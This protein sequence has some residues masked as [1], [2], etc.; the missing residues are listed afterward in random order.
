MEA[1]KQHGALEFASKE[2]QRDRCRSGGR[3]SS[4]TG[5]AGEAVERHSTLELAFKELQRIGSRS[6]GRQ[7]AQSA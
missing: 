7:A 4:A 3:S 2:L 1:V 5:A 6:G